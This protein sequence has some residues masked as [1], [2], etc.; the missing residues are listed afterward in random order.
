MINSHRDLI[1]WQKAVK[2]AADVYSITEKFPREELYGLTSQMRRASVSVASNI[3]EGRQRG[4][5]KDL[6]HF[7]RM[8]LGSTAELETQFDIVTQIAKFKNVEL[9][10]VFDQIIEIRKMLHGM[11]KKLN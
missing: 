11:L 6:S 4:T 9:G 2:L 1:V 5:V 3:A 10:S 8:S 7:L